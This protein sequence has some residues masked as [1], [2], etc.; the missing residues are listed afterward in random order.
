MPTVMSP[1]LT[2]FVT[3]LFTASGVPD[4]D[5]L[6]VARSLVGANLRGHDSHGVLRAPQY[7]SFL[8]RGDYRAGVSL[9]IE[10]ET[11]VLLVCDG[12]WGLGQVQANRLLDRIL[13]KAKAAGLSAGT[14]RDCGHIGRL[15]EYAERA[16]DAGIVLIATVNNGG[17]GQRVAPPGGIEP[18]LGTNPLCVA[19][20]TVSK[21]TPIVLDFGTSVAAEGK[22]RAHHVSRR[23]VPAG[24]L[25][26]SRGQPTQ[27]PAVLYQTPSGSILPLGGPQS[28]KGFGLALI[29]DLLSGGLS[30]G[31]CCHPDAPPPPARG[32][33]V[34]FLALDPAWFAGAES[35]KS[36]ATQL[37][38][39]LRATPR[40]E[41]VESILLPGDPERAG[42]QVRNAQG[43]PLEPN[44]WQ[45]LIDLGG[46][47]GVPPPDVLF[48]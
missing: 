25:L 36:K 3:R 22:V 9:V 46:R 39:Y 18:R 28:Y 21:E 4:E 29:L 11:P 2:Q 24:W 44:Q 37:A 42:F 23:P 27:D 8:E 26:D 1:A 14:I 13:P 47:L 7:V 35:L 30:G 17:S 32:N 16:T 31:G 10:R 12:Q 40:A 33:N 38:D 15:G 34:I 41:N 6:L 20:P 45:L 48:I 43:I 19:V 5:A